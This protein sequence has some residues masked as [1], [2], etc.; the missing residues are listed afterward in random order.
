[1]TPRA[2]FETQLRHHC[3]RCRLRLE[4]PVENPRS[5][6]CCR[7]CYRQLFVKRCLVCEKEIER[8]A[9]HQKLCRSV[10]CRRE[11]RD[12]VAHQMEGKF[13]A[14]PHRT[15]DGA[16]PSANPIEIGVRRPEKTDR[17]WRMV[18]GTLSDTELRLATLSL[19]RLTAA[20]IHRL[21]REYWRDDSAT[22]IKRRQPPVNIVGGYRFPDAPNID[23]SSTAPG[24]TA[25]P[26]VEPAGETSA[27]QCPRIRRASNGRPIRLRY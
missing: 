7:G 15:S 23:I 10:A 25:L 2:M 21:N 12:I 1:M 9:G 22:L 11:Y 19:D 16:S 24:K 3:R 18:A 20:R 8:T 13:G 26:T 4:E 14:K 5:A 17:P 27:V 6:F